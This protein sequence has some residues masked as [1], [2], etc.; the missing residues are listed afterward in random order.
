MFKIYAKMRRKIIIYPIFKWNKYIIN[1]IHIDNHQQRI[2]KM[3]DLITKNE[4][5]WEGF[6]T[7][8]IKYIESCPVSCPKKQKKLN[9]P[10]QQIIDDGQ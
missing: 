7:D 5:Y 9:M 6:S 1:N 2:N 4:Y 10:I 8:F 3:Q